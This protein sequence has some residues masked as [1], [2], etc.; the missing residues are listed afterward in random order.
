[1]TSTKLFHHLQKL[2]KRSS[3][4]RGFGARVSA[5][6]HA[7]LVTIGWEQAQK[8]N[9][10]YIMTGQTGSYLYMAPEVVRCEPY[11]EKV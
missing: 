2:L 9:E 11:D 6:C 7:E 3:V 1:V 5:S 10:Q 4:L 8:Q